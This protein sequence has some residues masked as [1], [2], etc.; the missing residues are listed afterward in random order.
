M[1]HRPW[2]TANAIS[3]SIDLIKMSIIPAAVVLAAW[4]LFPSLVPMVG[5]L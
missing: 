5:N 3:L 2:F 4:T 1:S